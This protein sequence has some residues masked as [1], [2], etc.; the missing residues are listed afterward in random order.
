MAAG[1]SSTRPE[2]CSPAYSHPTFRLTVT[3][4]VTP[5]PG[6]LVITV[7]YGSGVEIY[8]VQHPNL[9]PEVVFCKKVREGGTTDKDAGA[10]D[11]DAIVCDLWTDGA[12]TITLMAEGYPEK[13]VDLS[14]EVDECGLKLK[15][16]SITLDKGD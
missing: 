5:L 14:A 10:E 13:K 8:D 16:E 3:A 9:S 1:C 2:Q 6:D 4:D 7:K 11:A 12:A 15:E